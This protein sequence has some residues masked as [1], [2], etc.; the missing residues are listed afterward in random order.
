MRDCQALMLNLF[1]IGVVFEG[2]HCRLPRSN[3]HQINWKADT[4]L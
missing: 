2:C 4:N 3:E 1:S